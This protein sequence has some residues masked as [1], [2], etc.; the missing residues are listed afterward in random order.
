MLSKWAWDTIVFD[1]YDYGYEE[2]I[3]VGNIFFA[4]FLNVFTIPVDIL[5]SPLETI[6]LILYFIIRRR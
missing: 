3:E 4:I 1:D 6:A 2:R 5:L